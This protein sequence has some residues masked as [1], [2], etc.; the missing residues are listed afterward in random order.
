MPDYVVYAVE[1][2]ADAAF[3]P[4]FN[5]GGEVRHMRVPRVMEFVGTCYAVN[6]DAAQFLLA[7]KLGG[8]PA[9]VLRVPTLRDKALKKGLS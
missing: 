6:S 5:P 8:R 3:E 9:V 4:R 1:D 2:Q 7:D